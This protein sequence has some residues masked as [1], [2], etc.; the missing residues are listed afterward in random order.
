MVDKEIPEKVRKFIEEHIESFSALEVILLFKKNPDKLWTAK[1][2]SQELR[3]NLQWTEKQLEEFQIKHLIEKW[4]EAPSYRYN[5]RN[6]ELDDTIS[7][8]VDIFRQMKSAVISCIYDHLTP[9][10]RF[11]DAF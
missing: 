10:K 6:L 8:L 9:V 11:A 7:T 2:V 5:S 1:L 4:D 3:T